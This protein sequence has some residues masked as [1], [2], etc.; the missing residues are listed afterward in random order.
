MSLLTRCHACH[1]V[2]HVVQDQLKVSEGWVRCGRCG[3]VFNALEHLFEADAAA[4]AG[5]P[6]PT[7]P[8]GTS[9][10]ESDSQLHTDF[11]ASTLAASDFGP[12]P[13]PSRQPPTWD[14]PPLTAAPP[15]VP[16]VTAVAVPVPALTVVLP[17]PPTVTPPAANGPPAPVVPATEAPPPPPAP[18]LEQPPAASPSPVT[19]PPPTEPPPPSVSPE[20]SSTAAEPV[21]VTAD[22]APTVHPVPGFLQDPAAARWYH[23]RWARWMMAL[24]APLLVL[25]LGLQVLVQYRNEL[26]THYTGLRGYLVKMCSVVGCQLESPRALEQLVLVSS[27]IQQTS[28][29]NV[30]H[31][32]AELHNRARHPV[33]TPSL[34]LTLTDAYGQVLVRKMLQ[35]QELRS[36]GESIRGSN[37]WQISAF[38]DVGTLPVAGFSLV[39]F[40][41]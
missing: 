25:L 17:Q 38:I 31:L 14:L 18:A 2:F 40:Y 16:A 10:T 28:A 4:P 39:L 6:T 7:S 9:A 5:A 41:P 3:E 29:K 37:S 34:D 35:P 8:A 32:R 36:P 12:L 22:D 23:R 33:R 30:L 20:A 11:G 27:K 13:A 1:M 19:P 21:A 24:L 26:S 15:P